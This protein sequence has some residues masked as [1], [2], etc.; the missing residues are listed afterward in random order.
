MKEKQTNNHQPR[1]L[2][3]LFAFAQIAAITG[4]LV[5]F[6]ATVFFT[7]V[8]GL[9]YVVSNII[10][11]ALGAITNFIMGRF[12]VFNSTKRKIQHQAFRYFLVSLGS[13][14]LN[15]LGVYLMT[16]FLGLH[17]VGSKIVGS[18]LIGVTY[19]FFLQKNFVY[20]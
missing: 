16:E 12:W 19:N 4:S 5:D 20:K 7:E 3:T 10:G 11:A 13:L 1:K 14:I 2:S 8:V 6:L 15:T 17:Y 9:W 18:I